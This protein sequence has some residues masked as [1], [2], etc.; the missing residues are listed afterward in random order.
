M[1]HC[2]EVD[3]S[4]ST[5]FYSLCPRKNLKKKKNISSKFVDKLLTLRNDSSTPL[6]RLRRIPVLR[7]VKTTKQ[8]TKINIMENNGKN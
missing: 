3:S 8:K 2:R 1:G 6:L 4:F 5:Q 7:Q